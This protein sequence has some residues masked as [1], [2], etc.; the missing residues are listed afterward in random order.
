MDRLHF[1]T[2]ASL[3]LGPGNNSGAS[4]YGHPLNTPGH[5][6]IKNSFPNDKLKSDK[7]PL[8]ILL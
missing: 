8:V 4:L 7:F 3:R 5:P 2:G 6:Y 1:K